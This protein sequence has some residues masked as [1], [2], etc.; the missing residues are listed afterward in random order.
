M[1]SKFQSGFGKKKAAYTADPEAAL[2]PPSYETRPPKGHKTTEKGYPDSE[3]DIEQETA[4][5]NRPQRGGT[6][7]AGPSRPV[8]QSVREERSEEEY[9]VRVK[10]GKTRPYQ[11]DE[12][13]EDD[14]QPRGKGKGKAKRSQRDNGDDD[15]GRSREDLSHAV[16]RRNKSHSD[17]DYRPRPKS[18][19]R[20][21]RKESRS[22]EEESA[23]D[24]DRGRDGRRNKGK[25]Q[26]L[27]RTGDRSKYNK[28][29]EEDDSDDERITVERYRNVEIQDLS[30]DAVKCIMNNFE[31]TYVKLDS[32]CERGKICYDNKAKKLNLEKIFPLFPDY[33]RSR[34][35][36]L[37]EEM[38]RDEHDSG[39]RVGHLRT[40]TMT[41]GFASVSLYDAPVVAI[42]KT[43]C[44]RDWRCARGKCDYCHGTGRAFA[45]DDDPF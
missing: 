24:S 38:K 14:M 27:T 19:K 23:N 36:D 31:I 39:D 8:K 6:N 44:F 43:R 35:E 11:Y 2:P 22:S 32:L 42:V 37:E 1:A 3:D 28:H 30:L 26:A 15:H 9:N 40:N 29:R 4:Q 7:R 45:V 20:G 5:P 18:T 21:W 25:S 10:K 33:M 13:S 16:V 34:W 41:R 12:E 17:D